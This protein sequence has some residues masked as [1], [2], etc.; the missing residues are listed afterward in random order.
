MGKEFAVLDHQLDARA[1]HVHDAARADVEVADFAVAHLAV[2]QAD[3]VPAGLDQRVG[4]LA[5]QAV[6]GGLARQ[7]DRVGFAFRRGNPS[8]R[9]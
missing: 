7:R 5:Q 1:V 4:I 9:G 2:G 8:R 6:V 3:K